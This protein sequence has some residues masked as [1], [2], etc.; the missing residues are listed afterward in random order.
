MSFI[1]ALGLVVAAVVESQGYIVLRGSR[2]S[3]KFQANVL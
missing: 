2:Q 1:G 3:G